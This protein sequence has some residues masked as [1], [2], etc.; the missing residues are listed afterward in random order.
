MAAMCHWA[1]SRAVVD[2]SLH[3]AL[4]SCIGVERERPVVVVAVVTM[5]PRLII[6]SNPAVTTGR[7]A[8]SLVDAAEV[9]GRRQ[10]WK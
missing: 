7:R 8:L 1:R 4:V 3:I 5:S 6:D 2:R 9:V 10:W